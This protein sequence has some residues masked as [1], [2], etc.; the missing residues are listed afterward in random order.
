MAEK[1]EPQA[2]PAAENKSAR[3]ESRGSISAEA[4]SATALTEG[5]PKKGA[6]PCAGDCPKCI[7]VKDLTQNQGVLNLSEEEIHYLEGQK[8]K[9]GLIPVRVG[10]LAK[11]FLPVQVH[12]HDRALRTPGGSK[13]LHALEIESAAL[14]KLSGL[15]LR[16][17]LGL[18]MLDGQVGGFLSAAI[19]EHVLQSPKD[20]VTKIK[21]NPVGLGFSGVNF[22]EVGGYDNE[23][24][25]GLFVFGI[26]NI[27]VKASIFEGSAGVKFTTEGWAIDG[28]LQARIPG[29]QESQIRILT[30][31]QGQI[32]VHGSLAANLG[33][34]FK[35]S[36]LVDYLDGV[37]KIEGA[38]DYTTEKLS[39]QLKVIVADPA[40]ADAA[41]RAAVGPENVMNLAAPEKSSD[42]GSS[43]EGLL[44]KPVLMGWGEANFKFNDWLSGKTKVVFDHRGFV[45][46][47]GEIALPPEIP[48]VPGKNFSTPPVGPMAKAFYGIPWVAEVYVAGG[49]SFNVYATIAPLILRNPKVAGL[50]STD[51]KVLQHFNI[52]GSLNLSA[53]AGLALSLWARIGASILF[54]DVSLTGTLKS[55]AGV[56]AYA[57]TQISLGYQEKQDPVLGKKGDFIF[58]GMFEFAAQPFVRLQGDL[59]YNLDAPALSPVSDA[60]ETWP[61]LDWYY[62]LPAVLGV[63]FGL[64]DYVI[65][66][67]P[68]FTFEMGDVEFDTDKFL[69][70]A[71]DRERGPDPSASQKNIPIHAQIP[72]APPAPRTAV[73]PSPPQPPVTAPAPKPEKPAKEAGGGRQKKPRGKAKKEEVWGPKKGG[74]H[75][76]ED[77]KFLEHIERVQQFAVLSKTRS[78]PRHRVEK[79]VQELKNAKKYHHTFAD[80]GKGLLILSLKGAAPKAVEFELHYKPAVVEAPGP[81]EPTKDVGYTEKPEPKPATPAQV[82]MN[83]QPITVNIPLW[84][85]YGGPHALRYPKGKKRSQE[86]W[87]R[88]VESTQT[89]RPTFVKATMGLTGDSRKSLPD[90][91]L[92]RTDR[93]DRGHLV[94]DVLGGLNTPANLVAFDEQANQHGPWN[95]REMLIRDFYKGSIMPN[96][97]G[98]CKRAEIEVTVLYETGK[99]TRRPSKITMKTSFYK[100]VA[101]KSS[102]ITEEVYKDAMARGRDV[103][104]AD[105]TVQ[106]DLA[107]VP[108]IDPTPEQEKEIL[109]DPFY[110]NLEE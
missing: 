49:V 102:V 22:N 62:G 101:N 23:F 13:N 28:Y 12:G 54:H 83:S 73:N 42:R 6:C 44:V 3:K 1:M 103:T 106:N 41:M 74:V 20:L 61:F 76:T 68:N 60:N 32:F 11:G 31:P 43:E 70:A 46:V 64:K 17:V 107:Y 90:R 63:K 85:M 19:G 39:G 18:T 92:E 25:S 47:I 2:A 24:K 9:T 78:W 57:D 30:N 27:N 82:T 88:Y 94:A 79:R 104:T 93:E 66:T 89:S 45:T 75:A 110:K 80:D 35:G 109:K 99:H 108:N 37:G 5:A 53:E 10:T 55:T 15:G 21:S 40:S 95:K 56:R 81:S 51:P 14:K 7:P 91:I 86:D 33:P 26:N 48:L 50:Y 34:A 77:T 69:E 29:L 105:I 72:A 52:M 59:Q 98:S 58:T 96:L 97:K 4:S 38:L 8:N 87:K 36:V 84:R 65:G 67:E 100:D 71:V 16:P